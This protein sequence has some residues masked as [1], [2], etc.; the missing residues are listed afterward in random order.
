MERRKFTDVLG[1][2]WEVWEVYPR[3][4]ERPSTA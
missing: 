3:L 1:V 4:L 2:V